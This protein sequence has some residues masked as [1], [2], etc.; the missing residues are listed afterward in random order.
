[1]HDYFRAE[2]SVRSGWR[3]VQ[4]T[5]LPDMRLE[6][7]RDLIGQRDLLNLAKGGALAAA[8]GLLMGAAMQPDLDHEGFR[9][10][11]LELPHA[12]DRIELAAYDPGVAAYGERPPEYVIGTDYTRPPPVEEAVLAYDDRAIVEPAEEDAYEA[13]ILIYE[14]DTEPRPETARRGWREEEAPPPLYPS[15]QGNTHYASDLP[16]PP[17][18]PAD[19]EWD[20]AAA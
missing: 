1:M 20:P 7:M 16:E 5:N 18:L 9:A 14:A 15:R 17:P 11:H 6:A 8:A 10:P 4:E 19:A 13:P 3:S 12:G 2:T